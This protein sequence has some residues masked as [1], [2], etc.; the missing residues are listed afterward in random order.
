[1]RRNEHNGDA[2]I[3]G[4]VLRGERNRAAIVDA[5]LA[6]LEE[7]SPRPAAQDI[8]ARAGVSVRSVFQH[9]ADM[10][11]LYAALVARQIERVQELA[12][13]V[14]ASAPF[15]ERVD[16]FVAQQARLYERVTPV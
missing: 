6:L 2:A 8:A 7:G 13:D 3:D 4:R 11:T 1:M 16:A 5:L 15:H 10:E 12:D 14:D 9:F